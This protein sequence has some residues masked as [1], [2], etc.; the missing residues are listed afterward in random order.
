MRPIVKKTG[1]YLKYIVPTILIL[2][3]LQLE[4]LSRGAA[5]IFNR[6][7]AEQDMLR[8]TITVE[9]I[10]AHINGH[11]VFED[12]VWK[13]PFNN[14]ILS[15]PNGTFDVRLWDVMTGNLKATTIQKLTMENAIVSV[16][17][18]PDMQVDFVR[19]S[20]AAQQMAK[21]GGQPDEETLKS[22]SVA[23]MTEEERKEYAEWKRR[24]KAQGFTKRWQ[25]FDH[26]DRHL[27]L[28]I[29][30]RNC[31]F[32]VF[33][34]NRHYL[35]NGC[36]LVVGMNK[37]TLEHTDDFV[38]LSFSTSNFG[39]DMI[40]RGVSLNG[41]VNLDADPVPECDLNIIFFAVNP[42]SLGFGMDVKN[43]MTLMVHLT[44][45][46]TD[47]VGHGK[48]Q[49]DD[50]EFPGL[51]FSNVEGI[52]SYHNSRFDFTDVHA[53][54]FGGTLDAHG[55]YDLD[56][57][58]YHI[59]GHGENLQ[60]K[61]ALPG[62]GLDCPVTLEITVD[63]NGN[64][65]DTVYY[66]SFV[67]GKGSYHLLPFQRLSGKYHVL[68]H[69]MVFSDVLIELTGLKLATTYLRSDNGKLTLDP[70]T[71]YDTDGSVL[72]TYTQPKK[73]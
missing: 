13:D 1:H 30:F 25:N 73:E 65:K 36:D 21:T 70:V 39:G 3:F 49:M 4:F 10:V 62:E 50:L 71:L 18:G 53:N 48:V 9:K 69:D 57:R 67:S 68:Y 5:V 32:E 56:T 20:P 11:V 44:G 59:Y 22:V 63:S 35:L 43:P 51:A 27:R 29:D 55:D 7:M 31:L 6:A 15:I 37:D 47:P 26:Q 66:G 40:G 8:G 14:T 16:R 72:Y 42:Y 60:G 61:I 23:G 52:L 41:T 46:V 2:V 24:Q 17:L 28:E 45:P 58:R 54:V 12:L 19:H 38:N 64:A 34:K 33:Y